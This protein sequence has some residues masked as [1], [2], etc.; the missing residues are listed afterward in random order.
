MTRTWPCNI[1]I[2]VVNND[3]YETISI[4]NCLFFL[5]LS[6]ICQHTFTIFF[7]CGLETSCGW[8]TCLSILVASRDVWSMV[9]HGNPGSCL[10]TS[11]LVSCWTKSSRVHRTT[12]IVLDFGE[13][14][15]VLPGCTTCYAVSKPSR[16]SFPVV[17]NVCIYVYIYIYTHTHV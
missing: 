11:H 16:V 2:Q 3:A 10:M 7:Q 1:G 17:V 6:W 8:S 4:L 12:G 14:I 13:P 15:V 5:F 9:K